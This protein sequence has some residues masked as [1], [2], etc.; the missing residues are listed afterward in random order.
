METTSVFLDRLG[1]DL[2]AAY[3]C[4]A[5]KR[6]RRRIVLTVVV[7]AL[8]LAGAATAVGSGLVTSFGIDQG[9]HAEIVGAPPKHIA[10]GP[11]GCVRVHGVVPPGHWLYLFSHSLGHNRP[12][13]RWG[14]LG[15]S[16]PDQ[17][18]YDDDSNEIS[19]PARAEISYA[20]TTIDGERLDCFALARR[21]GTLPRG[22][23]IYILSASEYPGYTGPFD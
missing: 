4:H 11:S 9:K 22:T 2:R 6:R 5:A 20:C 12:I 3:V 14:Q 15:E 10:C 1:G 17:S 18:V 21:G 8:A 13:M 19:P 7:A 16:V 23:A